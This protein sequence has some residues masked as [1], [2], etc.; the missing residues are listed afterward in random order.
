MDPEVISEFDK[1]AITV[2]K[3]PAAT[4]AILQPCDVSVCFRELKRLVREMRYFGTIRDTTQASL[5]AISSRL[6]KRENCGWAKLFL[7]RLE[8]SVCS[9]APVLPL[10]FHFPSIISTFQSMGY[11]PFD[12]PT[13]LRQGDELPEPVLA[14]AER[15]WDKLLRLVG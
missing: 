12:L 15:S 7:E 8:Y 3:L 11:C 4:S 10:A 9:I 13:I 1:A 14:A 5:K 2:I 6:L